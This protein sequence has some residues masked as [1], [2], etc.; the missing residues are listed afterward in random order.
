MNKLLIILIVI[1]ISTCS[2][3][4]Q[5][6][7]IKGRVISEDFEILPQV[8]I[9]INDAVEVG[10]TD[11]NGFFQIVIPVSEKIISFVFV[12]LETTTIR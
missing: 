2:L 9:V 6:K 7:T 3:Y 11:L 12:G 8:S 5:T 4:S 1:G 10:R